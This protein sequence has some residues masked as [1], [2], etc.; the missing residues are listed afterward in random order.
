MGRQIYLQKFCLAFRGIEWVRLKLL[1]FI[2]FYHV[3]YCFLIHGCD[4]CH[5]QARCFMS[6]LSI[7]YAVA[8]TWLHWT[9]MC[10]YVYSC[11]YEYPYM[12]YA[13]YRFS[14]VLY[15]TFVLLSEQ[16]LNKD[17]QSIIYSECLAHLDG[18]HTQDSQHRLHQMTKCK[19]IT[20]FQ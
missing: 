11:V 8:M 18:C 5:F 2:W 10:V 16:W 4:L 20:L 13:M 3:F 1:W 19:T 6:I 12:F 17:V 14:Y 9:F 7:P 15:C